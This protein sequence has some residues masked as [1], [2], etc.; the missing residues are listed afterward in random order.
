MSTLGVEPRTYRS[1]VCRANP[2]RHAPIRPDRYTQSY[3][4]I[5]TFVGSGKRF[6]KAH[7]WTASVHECMCHPHGLDRSI[8]HPTHHSLSTSRR[9]THLKGGKFNTSEGPTVRFEIP[10][11]A[12]C[13]KRSS[14]GHTLP[15]CRRRPQTMDTSEVREGRESSCV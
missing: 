4:Q 14:K 10:T 1:E 6:S 9:E 11:N 13:G 8:S 3:V 2:L 15:P 12:G 5:P 7:E